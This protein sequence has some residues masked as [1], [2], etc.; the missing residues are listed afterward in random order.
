MLDAKFNSSMLGMGSRSGSG[1]LGGNDNAKV[2]V[3]EK[4]IKTL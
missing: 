2:K 1:A 4:Q 3:L